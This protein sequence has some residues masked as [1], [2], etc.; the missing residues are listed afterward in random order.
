[1][2]LEIHPKAAMSY[3]NDAEALL[4]E[5]TPAPPMAN[6]PGSFKMTAPPVATFNKVDISNWQDRLNDP[7]GNEIARFF[8]HNGKNMGLQ[9]ESYRKSVRLCE[10]T[11]AS[12]QLRDKISFDSVRNNFFDWI[13]GRYANTTSLGM[14]EYVL[15][16]CGEEVQEF[17]V[18]I[19][20]ALTFIESEIRIGKVTIKS[21][22]SEMF[23][24][25]SEIGKQFDS[26]PEAE[27]K[28]TLIWSSHRQELQGRAV[29]VM[30]VIAEPIRAFEVALEETEMSLA[31]LRLF[32]AANFLPGVISHCTPL[33]KENVEQYRYFLT[34]PLY[35][36]D[37]RG[38][39][40]KANVFLTLSN[41][42]V[43]RFRQSGLDAIN[44]LLTMES[45]SEFQQSLLDTLILYS[46]HTLAQTISEELMS[47]FA[48]LDSFL[49]KDNSES[50]QQNLGERI[51]FTVGQ[52]VTERSDII[53]KIKKV[54]DLRSK[55]VHHAK[56]ID[57]VTLVQ[58]VLVIIWDFFLRLLS[59]HSAIPDRK[60]FFDA[61]YQRKLA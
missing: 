8:E 42:A 44:D 17:E 28:R 23:D 25:L 38:V 19:P 9:G 39:Y 58:E 20:V 4:L 54:Y 12:N 43:T 45:R 35:L 52:S 21:F 57:E 50:I 10:K 6:P 46:R 41:E 27:Q 55:A 37:D 22:S 3:D 15:G 33:G 24:T 5:L 1:M 32:T 47:V 61:L 36:S 34:N 30:T 18:L 14:T 11:Q 53:E 2:K 31:V 49:L 60:A 56:K 7:F 51:A 26:T 16:K 13:K 29:S 40:E 48:A 59:N